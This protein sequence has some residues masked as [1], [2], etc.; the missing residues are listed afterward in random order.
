MT[1]IKQLLEKKLRGEAKKCTSRTESLLIEH[2]VKNKLGEAI[3]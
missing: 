3:K 2:E 1:V